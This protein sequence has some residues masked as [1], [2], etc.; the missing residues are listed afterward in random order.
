[1]DIIQV[2]V[3]VCLFSSTLSMRHPDGWKYKECLP[4]EE[5]CEFWLL[6]HE[7]LTMIFHKDLV[8]AEGGRLYLYNEHP[9]N[10]T[11][12]VRKT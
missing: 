9:S 11:T 12:E 7:Q 4:T 8:Y 5:V 2:A 3:F 10:F 1:M 6:I